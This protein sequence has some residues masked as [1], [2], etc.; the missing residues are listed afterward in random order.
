MDD[1]LSPPGRVDDNS[2]GNESQL[3]PK[4][5]F[6]VNLSKFV[7]EV[8][9]T[10]AFGIFFYTLKARYSGLFLSLWIITLFGLNISGAHYNPAI[11]LA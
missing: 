2:D 4:Q 8:F 5:F 11:T 6:L 7:V 10:A 1:P 9:G 3:S